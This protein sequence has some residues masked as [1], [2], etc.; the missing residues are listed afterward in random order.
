MNNKDIYIC[1]RPKLIKHKKQVMITI[2]A[3]DLEDLRVY[4]DVDNF[5]EWV[6]EKMTIELNDNKVNVWEKASQALY[7]E[8][9]APL[10][11]AYN[12]YISI[13]NAKVS[14]ESI[15]RHAYQPAIFIKKDLKTETRSWFNEMEE[16]NFK[17]ALYAGMEIIDKRFNL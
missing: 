15:M 16:G 3:E 9:I 5:S 11:I 8:H 1:G 13:G 7:I 10:K 14:V 2:D 6:R 12:D 4:C 17:N